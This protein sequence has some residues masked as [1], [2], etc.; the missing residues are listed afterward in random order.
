MTENRERIL[1]FIRA[2]SY[3]PSV[4]EIAREL[5]LALSTVQHHLDMLEATGQI[6][7]GPGRR[8]MVKD[9]L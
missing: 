5:G 9:P 8:I 3:S 6:Q 1:N 7:R 4:R 2:S